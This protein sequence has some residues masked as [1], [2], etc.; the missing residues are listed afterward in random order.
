M[1]SSSRGKA[2]SGFKLWL[3]LVRLSRWQEVRVVIDGKVQQEACLGSVSAIECQ[4]RRVKHG[5]HHCLARRLG[6][7]GLLIDHLVRFDSVRETVVER[8]I[9]RMG[10]VVDGAQDMAFVWVAPPTGEV[11]QDVVEYGCG[12]AV[13]VS[14]PDNGRS[15][16]LARGRHVDLLKG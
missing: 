8:L 1:P 10:G 9:G 11:V 4:F 15:E 14:V 13:V 5:R 7:I 3:E 6:S 16:T 12:D 2:E